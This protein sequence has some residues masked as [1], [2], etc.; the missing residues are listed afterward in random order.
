MEMNRKLN[1]IG[2]V[3]GAV[4]AFGVV[5][6][7]IILINNVHYLNGI[8]DLG[9][10][11]FVA[12]SAYQYNEDYQVLYSGEKTGSVLEIGI[13]SQEF[14]D[15]NIEETESFERRV[16]QDIDGIYYCFDDLD[17]KPMAVMDMVNLS[18][19]LPVLLL[20]VTI[21]VAV[22]GFLWCFQGTPTKGKDLGEILQAK[23]LEDDEDDDEDEDEDEE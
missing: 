2:A 15:F 6:S 7:L 1:A 18:I 5:I 17:A 10:D 11:T 19:K 23:K 12:K 21:V 22:G 20:I 16:Y 9:V 13:T 14:E 3:I 8:T 4:G